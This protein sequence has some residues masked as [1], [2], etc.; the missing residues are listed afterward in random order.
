MSGRKKGGN[1]PVVYWA[2]CSECLTYIWVGESAV[3]NEETI[4][5]QYCD[6]PISLMGGAE[7]ADSCNL[8]QGL[9]EDIERQVANM[10]TAV[11]VHRF[12]SEQV[13]HIAGAFNDRLDE[14]Q[15]SK[16]MEPAGVEAQQAH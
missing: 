5:C 1:R 12:L 16:D 14:I 7:L 4:S 6:S 11:D 2:I 3:A 15:E 8:L 10:P 13:G 9:L